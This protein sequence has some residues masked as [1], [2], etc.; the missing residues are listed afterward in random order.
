MINH[1]EKY[2]KLGLTYIP[3][4]RL[5]SARDRRESAGFGSLPHAHVVTGKKAITLCDGSAP[6]EITSTI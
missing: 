3:Q 5:L 2:V 4:L 6:K 1:Y